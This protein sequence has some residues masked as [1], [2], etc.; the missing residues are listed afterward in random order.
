[1]PRPSPPIP[2]HIGPLTRELLRRWYLL[3]RAEWENEA[4]CGFPVLSQVRRA[5][6]LVK[7][8][9]LRDLPTEERVS[10]ALA[11]PKR[12]ARFYAALAGDV[13]TA[14]DERFLSEF[15]KRM[16]WLY[17]KHYPILLQKPPK[18]PDRRLLRGAVLA[19]LTRHLGNPD[20]S[21]G[22]RNTPVFWTQ[23][24]SGWLL[25]TNVDFGGNARQVEY[26]FTLGPAEDYRRA[27]ER[28]SWI[29]EGE[30]LWDCLLAGEEE[31]AARVIGTCVGNFLRYV[32]KLIDGLSP[33]VDG[34]LIH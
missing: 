22:G 17:A 32:P 30:N 26:D 10:F 7:L 15:D 14:D 18:G 5:M 16:P 34:P 29:G 9:V 12:P 20:F 23:L 13:L 25:E 21:R 1:V 27:V 6:M 3:A 33:A 4:R 8:E 2:A 28:I 31:N 24:G 19:E 11:F